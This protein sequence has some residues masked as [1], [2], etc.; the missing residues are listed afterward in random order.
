MYTSDIVLII[1]V[2]NGWRIKTKLSDK[3]DECHISNSKLPLQKSK[4]YRWTGVQRLHF[5]T[6]DLFWGSCRVEWFAENISAVDT[7]ATRTN[8]H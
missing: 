6:Y 5:S 8:K 4:Y 2:N 3:R 1:K 7:N